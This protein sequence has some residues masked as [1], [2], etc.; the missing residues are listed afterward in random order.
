MADETKVG[1]SC[2][3]CGRTFDDED[4]RVGDGEVI[5][6]EPPFPL[7]RFVGGEVCL[8][9]KGTSYHNSCYYDRKYRLD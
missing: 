9:H 2:V 4:K 5:A 8:F 6:S 1:E 3:L 7:G